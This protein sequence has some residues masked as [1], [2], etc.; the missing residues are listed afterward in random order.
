VDRA[1][2][3][4]LV[5][6]AE[7][8]DRLEAAVGGEGRSCVIAGRVGVGK[9]RLMSDLLAREAARGRPTV[10][11]RATRSTAS[12]PFGPFACWA[13]EQRGPTEPD[14]L[15][16]LLAISAALLAAGELDSGSREPLLVGVDDA[17]MLDEASA[18]LL[19]HLATTTSACAMVTVRS[20]E[21][22]P[23]AVT[24]LWKES[25]A[26]RIELQPLA[27]A[28]MIDLLGQ[29]LGGAIDHAAQRRLWSLTSGTPLYLYE[30]V[31][32]A[33]D[34]EVLADEDGRWF[35]RGA[36]SGGDRLRELMRTH[37]EPAGTGEHELLVILAYGEPLPLW[38]LGDLGYR[39]ALAS[40]E[41][42]GIVI[43]DGAASAPAVRLAHPL[44]AEVLRAEVPAFAATELQRMLAQ[45]ALAAGWHESDPLRVALWCLD[46]G[47][48]DTAHEVL[49]AG[50]RQALAL[51]DWALADKLAATVPPASP[52]S[53]EA[54][55]TRAVAL[56]PQGRWAD[57][58]DL[59]GGLSI[60]ALDGERGAELAAE[61]ARIHAWL[62][63]W[64]VDPVQEL[65]EVVAVTAKLP[66]PIRPL[67]LV[68]CALQSLLSGRPAQA[69]DLAEHVVSATADGPLGGV[70]PSTVQVQALAVLAFARALQGRAG[71]ALAS[72]E[73]ALPHLADVLRTD[74]LP[75]NPASALL[76]GY[77]LALAFSGRLSDAAALMHLVSEQ[78]AQDAP[79][80]DRWPAATLTGR[81]ELLRGRLG[82]ARQLGELG[83]SICRETRRV[84]ASHWP[85][86]VLASAAAQLGDP[87]GA[88]RALDRVTASTESLPIYQVEVDM[89]QGW[90]NAACG[91]MTA[92][93][94]KAVTTGERAGAAG[95]HAFELLSL[96]D[97]AR[98]GA[99][100]AAAKR[101][102]E[103]E[104]LVDG[105]YAAAVIDYVQV[106]AR[107]D[108]DGL[109]RASARFEAMDALLLAAEAAAAATLAHQ[110]GGRQGSARTSRAR[111][112]SLALRCDGA[113]TPA[114][115]NLDADGAT[116]RLTN[117]EREV[118]ELAAL[119]STNR[120]IA[121]RLYVSI[122]TVNT[123][124]YRAY[125]KL[126]V[127][128][129]TEL[130]RLLPPP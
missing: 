82:A 3:W 93:R 89:A 125:A 128:D 73:P 38:L 6:R 51:S 31:R 24:S 68:H 65:D 100:E 87:D 34:Q 102:T 20:G 116:S 53:A 23:D 90:T 104:Q 19:L 122:R 44:Y 112:R 56:S 13:P 8:L 42:R 4:P 48:A 114:L 80:G 84:P 22:C 62:L 94:A 123:H 52:G 58:V 119:G 60:E 45:A 36:L 25:L 33:L 5:G 11:V 81:I 107:R 97:L 7:E 98:F 109:D 50:A 79:G 86:A 37:M 95:L 14:R 117:R 78:M 103:L 55:L 127:N 124:L 30:V 39:P 17:H 105:D 77:C 85:A 126:G 32:A 64:N 120:E 43:V 15:E 26:E 70:E 47:I 2:D 121:T 27:E 110:A 61:A 12:I 57:A 66:L 118:A 130:R 108:G 92:A 29:V 74:P 115:R 88:R 101:L 129:R 63:Y 54:L 46:G 67:A 75:G 28:E 21:P 9:S 96:L 59:L 10:L 72:A 83:L 40:A 1:V 106:L 71:E 35:W 113:R 99:A 16:T 69:A 41:A 91:L 76:P 18:A 111:A 49:L